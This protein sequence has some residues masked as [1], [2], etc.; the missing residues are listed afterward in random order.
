MKPERAI[1]V[2]LE[3]NADWNN[4]INGRLYPVQAPQGVD[5]PYVT[6][7]KLTGDKP[8]R[9]DGKETTRHDVFQLTAYSESAEELKDIVALM[10]DILDG[11]DSGIVTD[12]PDSLDVFWIGYESDSDENERP[13]GGKGQAP[14]RADVEFNMSYRRN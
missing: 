3:G 9:M 6:F 4:T 13:I 12:D 14:Y 11:F 10:V 7:E 1:I 2:L 8:P 5:M